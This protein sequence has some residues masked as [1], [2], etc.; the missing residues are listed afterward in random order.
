MTTLSLLHEPAI[1]HNLNTRYSLHNIYT[2]TG[3]ILIAINPY[4]K[5]NIYSSVRQMRFC[6]AKAASSK[7]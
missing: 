7:C 3:S 6:Y 5:L 2:F 4:Q 1:L